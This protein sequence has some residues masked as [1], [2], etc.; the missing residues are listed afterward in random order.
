MGRTLNSRKYKTKRYRRDLDQVYNDDMASDG[1]IKKL[2]EQE[3]DEL[4]PGMGQFYCI[5]CV[6]Y[7][8]SQVAI[9]THTSTKRHK[10]RLKELKSIPYTPDEADFAAGHN[11]EKFL[12]K[13]E[14]YQN[15]LEAPTIKTMLT[16]Q[17]KTAVEAAYKESSN[18][19]DLE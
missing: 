18:E 13:K 10:R 7:F 4:K 16:P 12:K 11:V 8:E 17:N 3:L 14:G 2:T 6:K 9:K 19:M 1:S 5:P 15:K